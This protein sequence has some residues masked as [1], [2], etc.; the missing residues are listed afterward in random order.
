MSRTIMSVALASVLASGFAATNAQALG[1]GGIGP[2][3]GAIHPTAPIGRIAPM[4]VPTAPRMTLPT[5]HVNPPIG[6]VGAVPC[7]AIVVGL[8]TNCL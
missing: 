3:T 2:G 5:F 4:A 6:A 7:G 1:A 8:R